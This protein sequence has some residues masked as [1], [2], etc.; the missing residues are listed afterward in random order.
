[1]I[2]CIP[3]PVARANTGAVLEKTKWSLLQ[4]I[5]NSYLRINW[6]YWLFIFL[7]AKRANR[8]ISENQTDNKY[9]I[10]W[11]IFLIRF[12]YLPIH[13]INGKISLTVLTGGNRKSLTIIIT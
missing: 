5:S 9:S 6:L 11:A 1:M 10:Y 12:P 8:N 4:M 3:I 7:L 2:Y 13:I